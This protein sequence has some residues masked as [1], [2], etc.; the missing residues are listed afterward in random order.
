VFES[1]RVRDDSVASRS[2]PEGHVWEITRAGPFKSSPGDWQHFGGS[3]FIDL[4]EGLG[5]GRPVW[6]TGYSLQLLGA[7]GTPLGSPPLHIHHARVYYPDDREVGGETVQAGAQKEYEL[8]PWKLF[9]LHGW[10]GDSQCKD[11]EGGAECLIDSLPAGFGQKLQSEKSRLPLRHIILDVREDGLEDMEY[12]VEVGVR[13]TREPQASLTR[14]DARRPGTG[15][16]GTYHI[17]EQSATM[18]WGASPAPRSGRVMYMWPH[19]HWEFVDS[20]MVFAA[21]PEQLGLAGGAGP[22][23]YSNFGPLDDAVELEKVGYSIGKAQAYLL[24][25]LARS[26]RL[27]GFHG[28]C[29]HAPRLMCAFMDEHREPLVGGEQGGGPRR[30]P[31]WDRQAHRSTDCESLFVNEGDIVTQVMF[32]PRA[33]DREANLQH[34]Y[35]VFYFLDSDEGT[36]DGSP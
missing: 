13:W 18:G 28:N 11:A 33:Q 6:I 7:D 4:S 26:Q 8:F 3:E 22:L 24:E 2:A 10:S 31:Q 17:S 36:A 9:H 23:D 19:G 16:F 20:L 1:C 14:Y 5:G 32:H 34:N 15:T 35:F 27:C 30:G 21:S 25:N 12:Y 29:T